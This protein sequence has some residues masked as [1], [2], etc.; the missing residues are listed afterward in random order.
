VILA[1]AERPP[2]ADGT[3]TRLETEA[4]ERLAAAAAR[5]LRPMAVAAS[6]APACPGPQAVRFPKLLRPCAT[7]ALGMAW[8]LC[9]E[10][11]KT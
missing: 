9:H 8:R 10:R 2:P 7:L 4:L 5:R 11:Y 3:R 6:A 1:L